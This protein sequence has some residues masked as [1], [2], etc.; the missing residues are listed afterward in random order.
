MDDKTSR[1]NTAETIPMEAVLFEEFY[2]DNVDW[3]KESTANFTVIPIGQS[4]GK[5]YNIKFDEEFKGV[6]FLI[7]FVGII[8]MR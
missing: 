1:T 8:I 3:W 4:N 7:L 6:E 2:D 5:N